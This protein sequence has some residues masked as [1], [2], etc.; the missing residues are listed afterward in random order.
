[1]KKIYIPIILLIP[2]LLIS[3][4]IHKDENDRLH[5]NLDDEK[6][7]ELII[8]NSEIFIDI[9]KNVIDDKNIRI[10]KWGSATSKTF[11][12]G[13]LSIY[14]QESTGIPASAYYTPV[15]SSD[16]TKFVSTEDIQKLSK[17]YTD[18]QK[19]IWSIFASIPHRMIWSPELTGN[20]EILSIGRHRD[21]V[22]AY[23]KGTSLPKSL[24]I[25][26]PDGKWFEAYFDEEGKVVRV[27]SSRSY[28]FLDPQEERKKVEIQ[29]NEKIREMEESLKKQIQE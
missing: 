26:R 11:G 15:I 6:I 21:I 13:S 9:C 22:L 8:S 23:R 28:D 3:S 27:N 4:Y 12:N 25:S 2:C 7:I 1:M 18:S 10:R 17:E 5:V 24:H 19:L 29:G 16:I 20:P 14:F